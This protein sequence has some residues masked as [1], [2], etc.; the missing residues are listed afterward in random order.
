[1]TGELTVRTEDGERLRAWVSGPEDAPPLLLITGG[2]STASAWRYLLPGVFPPHP[3]EAPLAAPVPLDAAHRVAVYDQRG[4]GGSSGE[5]P[6]SSSTLAGEHALAVGRQLLGDRFHLVGH[7]LGGMAA[8]ALVVAHPEAVISLTLMATS[9]GGVGLTL[10]E[11]AFLDN[12]TGAGES[13]ERARAAENLA[14]SVGAGFPDSHPAAFEQLVE[15]ALANQAPPE[16]W[17]AQAE[18]FITHDVSDSLSRLALPTLVICGTE[19]KVMPPANSAYL[20]EQ[21]PGA[22][23]AEMAGLGHALDIEAAVRVVD[24]ISGHIAAVSA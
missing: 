14:L 1:M 19:D 9:A 17:A 13:D 21:I 7:S 18:A 10:P 22:R 8:L 6:P 23:L 12:I 11:A 4:T 3:A 24:L 15:Q 16:S 5:V 20:A 2:A